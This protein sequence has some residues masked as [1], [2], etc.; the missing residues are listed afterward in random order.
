MEQ[1]RAFVERELDAIRRSLRVGRMVPHRYH[2]LELSSDGLGYAA[3]HG[4]RMDSE[5]FACFVRLFC[6]EGSGFF[7]SM[8]G[9][10]SRVETLTEDLCG[11]RSAEPWTGNS[12]TWI[13]QDIGWRLLQVR[14]DCGGELREEMDQAIEALAAHPTRTGVESAISSY[15]AMEGRW[16]MPPGQEVFATGYSL[17][18]GHGHA[19]QQIEAGV[20][21][22][23]PMTAALLGAHF[24]ERIL[25]FAHSDAFERKPLGRRFLST[26]EPGP[27]ADLARLEAAL[28]HAAPADLEAA[29]LRCVVPG[30]YRFRSG[31]ELLSFH[32]RVDRAL[33]PDWRAAPTLPEP[34]DAPLH[35]AVFR[36]PDGEVQVMELSEE[37]MAGLRNIA[38]DP[39]FELRGDSIDEL[40][41]W[42]VLL[43]RGKA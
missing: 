27:L 4:P 10:Q 9:L 26:L 18:G 12:W 2:S 34:L 42:G 43:P 24:S 11:G 17:P 21:S 28:S 38:E 6:T 8:E 40:L 36:E 3:A 5:E 1:G 29:T 37:T 20:E 15:A 16:V 41:G 23:L 31:L 32:C 7:S 22:A 39:E 33:D 19:L 14:A 13:A 30:P 25:E 35:L